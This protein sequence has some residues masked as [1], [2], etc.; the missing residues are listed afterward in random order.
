MIVIHHSDLDGRCAAAIVKRAA[1]QTRTCALP[2][3]PSSG[4]ELVEF[5][6]MD[7]KT[8]VP[9]DRIQAGDAVVI[10]DF[11]LK[12]GDMEKLLCITPEV[13]WIDHHATAKDYPYQALPGMRDFVDKS[14]SG[15]EL[16]WEYFFPDIEMPYAVKLV[17]SYD[18]FRHTEKDDIAFMEGMKIYGRM[19]PEGEFWQELFSDTELLTLQVSIEGHVV[20]AMRDEY[21]GEM[22]EA[23]G[24]E[25]EFEGLRCYA[26]NLYRFGS[27][28]YA[29]KMDG[30]DACIAFVFDGK[31]Y[32]VSMYSGKDK[33]IVSG[34]CKKHGGGGHDHA[35][36]FVCEKLPFEAKGG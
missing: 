6:E 28:A 7:Y 36:G 12:P 11:S 18:T 3:R 29:E 10:V 31:K 22:R 1:G 15:A 30:Y 26:L 16:A 35:A 4:G 21:C 14:R 9:F 2:W 23:F 17:G 19:N 34:V 8:P 33:P 20:E 32:T 24:F 25:A 13:T 5:I 27:L